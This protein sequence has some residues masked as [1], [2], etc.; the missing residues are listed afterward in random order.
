MQRI[1]L[2]LL[3]GVLGALAL[4]LTLLGTAQTPRLSTPE[5]VARVEVL[6]RSLPAVVKIVALEEDPTPGTDGRVFGSGFFYTQGRIVT[7]FHV[8]DGVR[9]I[10]VVLHNGREYPAEVFALDKGLDIAI[11]SVQGVVAPA[12][13]AFGSSNSLSVGMGVVVVGSPLGQRNMVSYGILSR[14]GPPEELPDAPSEVGLEIG[15]ALSTD[16]RT[17]GGNSGGPML[18][19]QGKVIGV[20]DAVLGSL[21]GLSGFGIAIPADQVRQSVEDLEKFGVAQRGWLGAS[22]VSLDDLDPILLSRLGLVS[23]QGVMLDKIDRAS[24]AATAGLRGAT[25]DNR[26]KLVSL[27]DV[28]LAINGRPVRNPAEVIQLIASYR[29]GDKVKLTLWRS[30]KRVEATAA[31]ITRR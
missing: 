26:N 2:A 18:N 7:N 15:N 20:M 24:P 5:E 30:G 22:L 16:A 21:S 29:P 9:N 11:L 4:T 25:R 19:L 12:T 28:L 1:P 6:R 27:G 23:G 3:G 31:M 8:V 13:L 17:E 10:R 14:I